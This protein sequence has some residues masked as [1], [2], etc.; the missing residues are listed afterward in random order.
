M[1]VQANRVSKQFAGKSVLTNVTFQLNRDDRVG[2]VGENGSGKTTFLNL[3]ARM[4][5]PDEGSVSARKGLRLGY[6]EQLI[7]PAAGIT[8]LQ[9]VRE[10]DE[11]IV[12]LEKRLKRIEAGNAGD[13]GEEIQE[14]DGLLQEFEKLDGYRY[15]ARISQ[16]LKGLGIES[17]TE[18]PVNELS[19]G[20]LRRVHLARV[21]AS[22]PDVLLLDEP[23]NHLDIFAVQWLEDYLSNTRAAFVVVSHDH[24]LLDNA[25]GQILLF[26]GGEAM[27]FKGGYTEAM[28][29][30]EQA[31][32]RNRKEYEEQQRFKRKEMAFIRKN[33]AGQKTKQAQSRL[34]RLDKVEWVDRDTVRFRDFRFTFPETGRRNKELLRMDQLSVGYDDPVVSGISR[35]IQRGDR[36]GVVGRNGSGKSTL[37]QTVGKRLQPLNGR[38]VIPEGIVVGFFDQEGEL[39]LPDGSVSDQIL[40]VD[41]DMRHDDLCTWLA[42]FYFFGD[43][44]DKPVS[45]LSGGERSRLR[46]AALMRTPIDLLVM[47]EPTNHLDMALTEG[48]T[49][50]LRRF[51]GGL[52]VVS[53]DRYFLDQVA[54]EVLALKTG[55]ATWHAG[56]VSRFL[57]K[58]KT[59]TGTGKVSE[60]TASSAEEQSPV[61]DNRGSSELSKNERLRANWRLEEVERLIADGETELEE[62]NRTLQLEETYRDPDAV[63][64]IK[65]RLSELEV[66]LENLMAEW[67]KLQNLCM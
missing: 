22:D 67:E 52:L 47:D 33:M 59:E 45:V 29:Q 8:V 50:A 42:R 37:L 39:P 6:V 15:D 54:N 32:E 57:E 17:L 20:E 48:L 36:V 30:L 12:G 1:L 14:L 18:R 13:T 25:V 64:R 28:T 10:A 34:K 51:T 62:L 56:G 31:R 24:Y 35:L 41:P 26:H 53:H 61:P 27:S 66:K 46:L 55:V 44:L 49:G 23:T 38:L 58:E 5:V 60:R 19:G 2:I 43:D 40:S 11:R 9:Y 63:V 16:I 65:G 4:S 7:Q 3:L 21:F